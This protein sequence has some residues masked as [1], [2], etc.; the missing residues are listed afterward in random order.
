[1]REAA[2]RSAR[3]LASLHELLGEVACDA[4][5]GDAGGLAVAQRALGLAGG[6][7]LVPE[8]RAVLV[9]DDDGVDLRG[10]TLAQ[11]ADRA[12]VRCEIV[13]VKEGQRPHALLGEPGD[14]T[15][16]VMAS[17]RAWKGASGVSPA[18]ATLV[19]GARAAGEGETRQWAWLAPRAPRRGVH[20]PG[21]GPDVERALAECLFPPSE[22]R[23]S[24]A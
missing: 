19:A 12:G 13:H 8:A 24:P 21:T 1:L 5:R 11:A 14:L 3:R 18:L 17:V 6:A 2:E 23:R 9:L 16:V 10:R 20:V 22:G 7:G 4:I 15:V